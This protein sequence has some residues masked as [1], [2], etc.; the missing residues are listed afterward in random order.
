MRN[1]IVVI[2]L[3]L[4]ACATSLSLLDQSLARLT[5]TQ[6]LVPES[7]L[8][9][10]RS[11]ALEQALLS[12]LPNFRAG[13]RVVISGDRGFASARV[14]PRTPTRTFYI[15]DSVQI[16]ALADRHGDIDY[17][18][19]GEARIEGDS[20][21]ANVGHAFALQPRPGLRMI[22]GEGGCYWILRRRDGV[23]QIERVGACLVS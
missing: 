19:V 21:I 22:Y 10:V 18:V 14:L 11:L 9:S 7:P 13:A 1:L 17:L 20:A 23:W 2:T 3:P 4:I 15:L 6:P 5:P 16:L 12:G 8:D